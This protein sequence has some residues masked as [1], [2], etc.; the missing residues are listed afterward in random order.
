MTTETHE[1]VIKPPQTPLHYFSSEDVANVLVDEMEGLETPRGRVRRSA[2]PTP[3]APTT[4][5][6]ASGI[7]GRS[8]AADGVDLYRTGSSLW[9]ADGWTHGR[10]RPGHGPGRGPQQCQHHLRR[11]R[12]R[13]HL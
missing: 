4:A 1:P 5:G 6:V 9:R 3:S 8:H 12:R 10:Q 2:A 11:H 13:R 7:S